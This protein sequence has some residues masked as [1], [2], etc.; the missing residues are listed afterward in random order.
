MAE[1]QT[2]ARTSLDRSFHDCTGVPSSV[3]WSNTSTWAASRNLNLNTI[4]TTIQL[5]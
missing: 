1:S 3:F 5:T 4:G 2:R